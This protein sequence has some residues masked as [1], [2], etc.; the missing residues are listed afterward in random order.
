VLGGRKQNRHLKKD[1]E[2]VSGR[3]KTI[4]RLDSTGGEKYL[5]AKSVDP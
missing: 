2:L 3:R 4:V 5:R 1:P